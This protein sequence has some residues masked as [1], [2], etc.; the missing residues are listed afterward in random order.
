MNLR[1]IAIDIINALEEKDTSL[2]PDERKIEI[3]QEALAVFS[4]DTCIEFKNEAISACD[5]KIKELIHPDYVFGLTVAK[6]A[7]LDTQHKL[8]IKPW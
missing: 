6:T 4:H 8:L 2:S 5:K 7:I 3:I 1:K